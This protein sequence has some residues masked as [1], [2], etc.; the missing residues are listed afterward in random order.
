[1]E[2]FFSVNLKIQVYPDQQFKL[3]FIPYKLPHLLTYGMRK[4]DHHP[5]AIYFLP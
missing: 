4:Y 2:L 3:N 1:M 5:I